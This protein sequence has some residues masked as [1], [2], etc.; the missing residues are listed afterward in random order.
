MHSHDDIHAAA[1]SAALQLAAVNGARGI[2][3]AEQEDN[4]EVQA[5]ALVLAADGSFE[6][7]AMDG[8]GR[9]VGGYAL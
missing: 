6:V 8:A 9:P 1:F 3:A 7:T 4:P 2:L 5:V